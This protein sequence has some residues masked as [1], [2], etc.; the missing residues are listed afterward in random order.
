MVITFP[1]S[2]CVKTIGDKEGFIY[3][4]KCNLWVHIKCNNLIYMDYKNFS[5]NSDPRFCL[6]RNSQLFPFDTLTIK[7]LCNTYLVAT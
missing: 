6:R 3:C 1:C 5:G 2:I 7:E 4:N